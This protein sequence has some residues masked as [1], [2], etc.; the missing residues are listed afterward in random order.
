MMLTQLEIENFKCIKHHLFELRMLNILVGLNGMGKSSFIETILF[1]DAVRNT[2]NDEILPLRNFN[3]DLGYGKDVLYQF[4]E[5]EIITFGLASDLKEKENFYLMC[6]ADKDSLT[7]MEKTYKNYSK[8]QINKKLGCLK[9]IIPPVYYL[10]ASRLYPQIVYP[11]SVTSLQKNGLGI[12]GENTVFYLASHGAD[13]IHHD[14]LRHPCSNAPT[15]M[16]QVNAWMGDISPDIR[17]N[18]EEIG[19]VDSVKMDIQYRQ[20]SLGYTNRFKPTHVGLGI[21]YSLPVITALLRARP[22]EL[23]IIDSPESNIHP[24]GQAVIGKLASIAAQ[25]GVQVILETHSD[26]VINGIRVA[27]KE[28]RI[29]HKMT[30]FFYFDR[31]MSQNE[32]YA[33]VSDINVDYRGELSM[34]P[35]NLLAEWGSQL[36]R[37]I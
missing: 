23:L 32:Q 4:A 11:K 31:A 33:A 15:L 22:G 29:D 3:L 19:G 37:L 5:S 36:L 21:S 6:S 35:D 18:A 13:L 30:R 28:G 9:K 24:Q 20:Q 12:H 14:A 16:D 26:H 2:I 10:S 25:C 34:Y 7:L 1:L 27:C 17:I 8:E